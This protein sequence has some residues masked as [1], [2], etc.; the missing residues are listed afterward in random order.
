MTHQEHFA[1][2]ARR[3]ERA[4]GEGEGM[5]YFLAMLDAF[6]DEKVWLRG[7]GHAWRPPVAFDRTRYRCLVLEAVRV[8][9]HYIEIAPRDPKSPEALAALARI[10][11]LGGELMPLVW[12]LAGRGVG[13]APDLV[14]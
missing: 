6:E 4:P 11:D 5:D 3:I 1:E 9:D 13:T 8:F 10:R 12:N 14:H 7:D 2:L